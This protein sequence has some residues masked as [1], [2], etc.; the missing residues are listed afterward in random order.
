MNIRSAKINDKNIRYSIEGEG[1]IIVLLHGFVECIEIWEQFSCKLSKT[2]KVICIELPGHGESE[3][4]SEV[5]TMEIMAEHVHKLINTIISEKYVLIGHSMGGYIGLSFAEKYENE[6]VGLGLFH[7]N[8]IADT[9]EAKLGRERAAEIIKLNKEN[10][11]FN[12]IPNLF[13]ECN[14]ETFATEIIWLQ[15]KAKSLTK[16]ALISC[17]FGMKERTDKISFLIDTNLPIMFIA[18]KEDERSPLNSLIAQAMLPK[19]SEILILS[20][21]GHTGYIEKETET[22]EFIRDFARKAFL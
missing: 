16:E 7:S 4:I 2:N 1:A 3:I 13:A 9:P 6:L 12:F 19:H 18:G 8:A 5:Q 15:E 20:N 14:R 11:I 17:L 21:C 10:Y 22:L